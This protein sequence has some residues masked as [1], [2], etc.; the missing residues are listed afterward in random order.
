MHLYV[1]PIYNLVLLYLSMRLASW[2]WIFCFNSICI[3]MRI[4]IFF[5]FFSFVF[6][7]RLVMFDT[8]KCS[9]RNKKFQISSLRPKFHLLVHWLWAQDNVI[10]L[11]WFSCAFIVC[12]LFANARLDGVHL[13]STRSSP[14]SFFWLKAVFA[15]SSSLLEQTK[16]VRRHCISY[17]QYIIRMFKRNHIIQALSQTVL[18]RA[19]H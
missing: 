7:Q 1:R 6:A 13:L 15:A 3:N 14:S 2:C 5:L 8:V 10:Y 16:K 12:I 18:V 19:P 4:V 11:F 9:L 17:H